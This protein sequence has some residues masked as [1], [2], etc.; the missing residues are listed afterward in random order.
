MLRNERFFQIFDFDEGR[1]FEPDFL[2][3][4]KNENNKIIIYQ[5]FIEVKGDLFKDINGKFDKSKE[6]WKQKFLLE[7]E[8]KAQLTEDLIMEME[9]KDFKLIGLPFYNEKLKKEFEEAFRKSLEYEIL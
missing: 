3:L 4:L 6:G 9:N 7:I 2:M 1:A 8:K 5:I